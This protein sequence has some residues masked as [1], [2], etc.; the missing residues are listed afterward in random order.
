MPC[1]ARRGA[2]RHCAH[3]NGGEDGEGAHADEGQLVYR[4]RILVQAGEEGRR[5][6]TSWLEFNGIYSRHAHKFA[7]FGSEWATVDLKD[8][9]AEFY[10]YE[11]CGLEQNHLHG[12]PILERAKGRPPSALHQCG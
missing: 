2:V 4:L 11:V 10:E 5:M 3:G 7:K 12:S 6:D 8:V 9:R 1:R